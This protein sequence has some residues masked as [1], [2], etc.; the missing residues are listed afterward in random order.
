[1]VISV[2]RAS[3]TQPVLVPTG[4]GTPVSVDRS[5]YVD[6]S[7]LMQSRRGAVKALEVVVNMTGLMY[8]F[9]GLERRAKKCLWVRLRWAE[10]QLQRR[11]ERTDEQLR[12]KM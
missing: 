6:D 7:G 2:A 1:M 9:L 12:C 4:D 8:Y 3:S 5:W 11:S 10:G